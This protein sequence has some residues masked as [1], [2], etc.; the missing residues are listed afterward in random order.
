MV[1]L[2]RVQI[3][4]KYGCIRDV[5]MDPGLRFVFR[6]PT[7]LSR[8]LRT[9]SDTMRSQKRV[10]TQSWPDSWNHLSVKGS[11]RAEEVAARRGHSSKGKTARPTNRK[12]VTDP[13]TWSVF[14]H[15]SGRWTKNHQRRIKMDSERDG[16]MFLM[17][18]VAQSLEQR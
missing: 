6:L 16:E 12:E 18:V 14:T 11:R 1:D 10:V 13:M 17:K 4:V 8:L 5:C 9:P 2:D 3:T 7:P 15:R